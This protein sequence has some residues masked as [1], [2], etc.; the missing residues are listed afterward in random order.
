MH[1]FFIFIAGQ[2]AITTFPSGIKKGLAV[3]LE[4]I[5]Y[6]SLSACDLLICSLN[7]KIPYLWL[8][9]ESLSLGLILFEEP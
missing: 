1:L 6:E 8:V 7:A 9:F 5:I 2:I 3:T 4:E